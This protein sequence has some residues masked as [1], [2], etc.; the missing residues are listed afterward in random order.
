MHTSNSILWLSQTLTMSVSLPSIINSILNEPFRSIFM[1]NSSNFMSGKN[2]NCNKRT[3]VSLQFGFWWMTGASWKH[4]MLK[5]LKENVIKL[6]TSLSPLMSLDISKLKFRFPFLLHTRSICIWMAFIA[7]LTSHLYL[8][9][10]S[11]RNSFRFKSEPDLIL[12]SSMF[13]SIHTKEEVFMSTEGNQT[14]S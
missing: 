8:I 3:N 10:Y 5:V 7:F 1:S 11:D 9:C 14:S 6:G 4:Q 12:C 13:I 2:K